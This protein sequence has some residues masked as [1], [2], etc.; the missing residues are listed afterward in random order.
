MS[1]GTSKS[2][3][4]QLIEPR[5]LAQQQLQLVGYIK[6]ED[7]PRV[8]TATLNLAPVDCELR[9]R[10]DEQYRRL[11]EGKLNAEIEVSCQRCMGAL[12]L[13]V[14]V[15]VRLA[16]V[17]DEEEAK[18]LPA[19]LDP[20]I[21]DEAETSLYELVEEEL[22]LN[23]PLIN[24]HEHDCIDTS[25]LSVGEIVSVKAA[26]KAEVDANPFQV[27]QKLK[28]GASDESEES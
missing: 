24:R 28:T 11:I 19:S 17:R 16:V 21:V 26:D 1:E 18:A 23:I 7:L 13:S 4:P 9:F 14:D 6:P 8:V 27:L 3:L 12:P 15:D 10:L 5:K 20:L 25:S 2:R 22:L